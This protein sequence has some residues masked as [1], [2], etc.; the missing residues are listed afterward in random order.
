M[1]MLQHS[2][3]IRHYQKITDNMV[4]LWRRGYKFDEIKLHMDGYIS[5]LR[6]TQTLEAYHINRLEEKAMSFLRDPSNFELSSM[7]QRETDYY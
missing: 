1:V 5:C 2:E 4:D 6:Q 3:S 7:V